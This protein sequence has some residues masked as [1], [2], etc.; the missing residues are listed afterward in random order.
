[1]STDALIPD[2]GGSTYL[3]NVGRQSFLHGSITQKTA[4]N[5][6]MQAVVN[7]AGTSLVAGLK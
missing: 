1:M 2:D 7:I 5:N 3:W 4:L 6:F